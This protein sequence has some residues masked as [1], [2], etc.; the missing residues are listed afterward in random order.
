MKTKK[1]KEEEQVQI[2]AKKIK[3]EALLYNVRTKKTTHSKLKLSSG[4]AILEKLIFW[5]KLFDFLWAKHY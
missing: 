1:K 5:G 2:R 3:K 4:K